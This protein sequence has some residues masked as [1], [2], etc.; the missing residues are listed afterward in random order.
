M[1]TTINGP[2]AILVAEDSAEQR[3]L[4][5]DVLTQA[6]YRVLQAG[7]GVEP[8]TSIHRERPDLVLMDVTMPGTSGWNVVRAMREDLATRD[9]P[10]IVVT[11]LSAPWDR[12]ASI[13]GGCDE[14]L[15][16][17]VAPRRLLDEVN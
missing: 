2:R 7:D 11:E 10:I 9:I 5:V 15:A 1:P 3:A 6:G 13:A 17:P 12:D 8:L 4:Y 16:K 14:Y